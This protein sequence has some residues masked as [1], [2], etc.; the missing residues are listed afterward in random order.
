MW[1]WKDDPVAKTSLDAFGIKAYPLHIADVNTG[2]ETGMI[3]SFYSPP[4]VAIAFQWYPKI[5]YM[6]DYSMV[7]STGALVIKKDIFYSLS[8]KNQAIMREVTRKFSSELIRLARKENTEAL[9]ILKKNGIMF[10]KPSPAQIISLQQNA[11][12]IYQKHMGEI[13]S[14]DLFQKVQDLLLAYRK[15]S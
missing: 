4:L 1:V 10:E 13:Y 7:N 11:K 8:E 15:S 6:L 9:K 2:L 3:N 14:A 12:T 5:R